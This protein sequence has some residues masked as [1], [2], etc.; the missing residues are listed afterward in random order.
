M[1]EHVLF[2]KRTEQINIG[3]KL[4]INELTWS[5]KMHLARSFIIIM[6]VLFYE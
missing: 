6:H 5:A 3:G 2:S 4:K 1:K